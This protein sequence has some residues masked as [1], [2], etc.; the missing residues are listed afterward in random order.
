MKPARRAISSALGPSRVS[1]RGR[2][3]KSVEITLEQE[4]KEK[5]KEEKNKWCM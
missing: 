5:E 2:L 3:V 1:C 4:E